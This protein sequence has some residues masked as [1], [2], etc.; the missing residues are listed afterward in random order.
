MS[1]IEYKVFGDVIELGSFGERLGFA[2]VRIC[3]LFLSLT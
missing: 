2:V 3:A 1:K